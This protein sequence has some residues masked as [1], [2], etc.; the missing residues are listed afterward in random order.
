MVILVGTHGTQVL[1]TPKNGEVK[2][3]SYPGEADASQARGQH[4]GQD[5]RVGVAGREVGVEA[6]VLPVGHLPVIDGQPEGE[7][8]AK[9]QHRCPFV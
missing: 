6:R 2:G 5:G 8:R 4:V 7:K 1:D 9:I 3:L